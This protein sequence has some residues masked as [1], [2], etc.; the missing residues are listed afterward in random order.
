MLKMEWKNRAAQT[1]HVTFESLLLTH[2]I[3]LPHLITLC[4]FLKR[5]KMLPYN[6]CT[7]HISRIAHTAWVAYQI[8]QQQQ[9]STREHKAR[10]ELINSEQ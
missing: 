7:T 4:R 9:S 3:I 8:Q 10:D 1:T 2:Y 5:P 6:V